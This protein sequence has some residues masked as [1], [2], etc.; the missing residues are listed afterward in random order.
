MAHEKGMKV[1]GFL[2]DTGGKLKTYVD[3]SIIIPSANVQRIQEG[4]ITVAHILCELVE[5]ELYGNQL[6]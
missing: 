4:H 1:V 5:L 3:L 2:G 6:K